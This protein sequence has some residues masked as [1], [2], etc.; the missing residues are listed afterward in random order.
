MKRYLEL[1]WVDPLMIKIF[2]NV[3]DASFIIDKVKALA[4]KYA[5]SY[6]DLNAQLIEAQGDLANLISDLTGDEF[7]IRGLNEFKNSLKG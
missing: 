3:N 1:K 2:A 5:M 4:Q 7:A 6:N